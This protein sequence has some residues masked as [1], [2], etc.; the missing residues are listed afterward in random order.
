MG[1]VYKYFSYEVLELVFDREGFCGLKC[2]YPKDYNDPF[3]LF[4]SLGSE[5]PSDVLAFYNDVVQEIPQ[6]PTTC[7]SKSPVVTP[8]WA[9]Y[10][11]NQTGFVLEFDAE[12]LQEW[13]DEVKLKDV[14]YE[15]K[16]ND[17]IKNH[18][19]RAAV[20]KKPRHSY[21]LKVAAENIAYF[22]KSEQW[23]YEQESRLV[24]SSDD[25]EVISGNQIFFIPD[26]IVSSIIVGPNFP[27]DKTEFSQELSKKHKICSYCLCLCELWRTVV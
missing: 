15:N 21:F 14:T 25:V 16:A 9:H 27:F 2:S 18:L 26:E 22:T 4:L 20:T 13:N 11:G 19:M 24:L 5:V 12:K 1:K 3:E 10:G 17:V 6:Y 8:M 7:F 23:S